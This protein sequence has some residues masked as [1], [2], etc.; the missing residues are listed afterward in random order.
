MT[1]PDF[2]I[3][4]GCSPAETALSLVKGRPRKMSKEVAVAVARAMQRWLGPECSQWWRAREE[5]RL[6]ILPRA[7]PTGFTVGGKHMK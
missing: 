7:E 2:K 5:V 3:G 1:W 6:W 4:I